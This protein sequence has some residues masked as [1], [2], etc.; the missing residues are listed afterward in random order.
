M[1]NKTSLSL[2]VKAT[3]FS[4]RMLWYCCV[5]GFRNRVMWKKTQLT[6]LWGYATFDENLCVLSSKRKIIFTY[7]IDVWIESQQLTLCCFL[8][9]IFVVQSRCAMWVKLSHNTVIDILIANECNLQIC[10]MRGNVIR[11]VLFECMRV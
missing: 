6:R 7:L 5:F 3:F 4:L 11:K 8:V 10:G 1:S 9:F 2:Q